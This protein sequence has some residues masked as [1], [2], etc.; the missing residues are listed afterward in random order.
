MAA[1]LAGGGGSRYDLGQNSDIN[2]TPFVDILLVLLIIFMVAI[3]TA[4]VSINLDLPPPSNAPPPD[5]EPI[6]VSVLKNGDLMLG[7][8]KSSVNNVVA[9]LKAAS[10]TGDDVIMIRADADVQYE[11]FMAVLNELQGNGFQKIGLISEDLSLF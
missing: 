11:R 5:R 3:P 8:T 4:T 2:V 9:D 1:K 6:F 7:E 10:L